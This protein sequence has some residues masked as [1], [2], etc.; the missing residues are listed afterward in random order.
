MTF[1]ILF[2]IR[3]VLRIVLLMMVISVVSGLLFSLFQ[4]LHWSWL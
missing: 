2:P 3:L 4:F 1:I